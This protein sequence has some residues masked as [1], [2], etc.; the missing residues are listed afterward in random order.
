MQQTSNKTEKRFW[1]KERYLQILALLFVL[2]LSVFLLLN[3]E[4]VAELEVYGYLGVF[5]ISIITCS[6]IVVPVPGWILVA[7]LGAILNPVL[8]GI[9]SGLGGTIG[10]MTGY[11]LGYG[12]RLAMDNVGLYSRMVRWMKSWGSV[13]IFILA[14]IPNP[15]FDLAGAAA[16]LLRFP[17]W[18]FLLFGAAGRIPKHILFAYIGV[19][20]FQLLPL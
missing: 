8:V 3:R 17:V 6:S 11:L 12:G 13:T 2:A 10:E 4:K 1:T 7:A 9:V 16:G 15:F 14:L 20:G 5:L 19:W 18:K